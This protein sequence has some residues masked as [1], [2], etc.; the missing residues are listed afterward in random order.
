M[1]KPLALKFLTLFAFMSLAGAKAQIPVEG[2]VDRTVYQDRVSLRI[3]LEP[4]SAYSALLDTIPIPVGVWLEVNKV[5]YHE[6]SVYRTNLTNASV[7][8][9]LVRFVIKST[10][11]KDSEWG[12]PPWTPYPVINSTAAE[13]SEA[14]LRFIVP[15]VYPA[16][17]PLPMVVWIDNDQGRPIRANGLLTAS[18]QPPIQLRRGVG[19][20]FLVSAGQTGLLTYAAELPGIRTNLVIDLETNTMWRSVSGA[21]TGSDSW[22]ANSRIAVTNHLEIPSG[23]TL[24][25]GEGTIVRL[26]S[27]VNLTNFGRLVINGSVS[28]PVV[29]TPGALDQPWGGI[30]LPVSASQVEATGTIFTRSGSR[31]SGF[32]G[33]RSEQCLFYLDNHSQL[34]LTDCA[35]ID[36]AGQF[37]HA[38]NRGLPWN[39][40]TLTRCLV[41][42]CVTGGE[43]NGCSMQILQSALIEM[44]YATPI[45]ADDDEDGIYFTAGDYLVKDSLVGWT[46]DDGIDSGSGDGGSVTVTNSWVESTYHEA[47]AWSGGG[48]APGPRVLTNLHCV[49]IN[50]GQGIEAGYSLGSGI[51][52]NVYGSDC[53]SIGNG[54]GLRFGDNYPWTYFG[55]L[56]VTNSIVLNNY[57]DVWGMNFQDWTYRTNAMDIQGNYLTTPNLNHPHN[58]VWDPGADGWRLASFMSTRPNVPVGMGIATWTNQ[59][60]LSSL[61]NG[62]PIGLS[63]FS[64]NL[65]SVDYSVETASGVTLTNGTLRFEPGETIRRIPLSTVISEN[66]GL[67]RVRLENPVNSEITGLDRF[68]FVEGASPGAQP[69]ALV[70]RG[71]RWRYATNGVDLGTGWR[72][73]AFDD[74]QWPVGAGEL[75]FGDSGDGRPETTVI[76]GGPANSR[77]PTLYFRHTFTAPNPVELSALNLA[78]LYDDGAVVYLND[79]E[80]ARFNMPTGPITYQ[81]WASGT[82]PSETTY[83]TG[84]TNASAL[85]PGTNV[86]AVEVHQSAPDSSDLSFDLELTATPATPVRLDRAAFNAEFLLYWSQLDYSLEQADGVSGPWTS[87]SGASPLAIPLTERQRFYRLHRHP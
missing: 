34:T 86:M 72:S 31:Q 8:N 54:I 82:T 71:S 67:V 33:H 44:P 14:H 26:A 56:R 16:G 25:I 27:G 64:T 62:L 3:P 55:F 65:V 1:N 76:Y 59:A 49:A 15:P 63:C 2:V 18:G 20:G 53:L 11:R 42:K 19:S 51:S 28:R 38:F 75:G 77:F 79:Q 52:P 46:R 80:I 29:F 85:L 87:V 57:R 66:M 69:I 41:Q 36:L 61:S 45:F 40:I 37:G 5:D 17:L 78:L 10:E 39:R 48:G 30:F 74:S 70:P 73:P 81:T 22:P 35:A 24:T 83:F 21:L 47:F 68:Y 58:R 12:L 23:A 43:W 9:R 13:L 84:S 32:A 7:T 50:C 60:E 6:L 4:D